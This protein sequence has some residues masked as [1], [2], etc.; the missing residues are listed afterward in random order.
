MR[1]RVCWVLLGCLVIALLA[2]NGWW[3]YAALDRASIEKYHE[4]M[5][6]ERAEGLDDALAAL[7][8]VAAMGAGGPEEV[9]ARIAEAVEDPAPYEKDGFTTVGVLTL[10]FGDDG[11]LVEARTIY[12]VYDQRSRQAVP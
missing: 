9:V 7:P 6:Y 1:G 2:S 12:T 5:L 3:L 11:D 10:R 8:A 4:Q